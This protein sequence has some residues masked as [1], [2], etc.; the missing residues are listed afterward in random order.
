[1]EGFW[2]SVIP[3]LLHRHLSAS[4]LAAAAAAAARADT[5]TSIFRGGS[6]GKK[7]LFFLCFFWGNGGVGSAD[8]INKSGKTLGRG[9]REF[10][11]VLPFPPPPGEL[12]KQHFFLSF[13]SPA[14]VRLFLSRI[15]HPTY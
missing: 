10:F 4:V 15:F 14:S 12:R 3:S 5:S 11:S 8:K 9:E 6:G 7:D 13:R 2:L 1:M